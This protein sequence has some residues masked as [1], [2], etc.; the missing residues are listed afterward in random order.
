M[1]PANPAGSDTAQ[2]APRTPMWQA[3]KRRPR[4]GARC[5]LLPASTIK[6]QS[7]AVSPQSALDPLERL[8]AILHCARRAAA[9]REGELNDLFAAGEADAQLIPA[10]VEHFH[11]A[12]GHAHARLED[13][14]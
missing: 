6:A 5:R 12:L 11:R 14:T 10:R 1:C 9:G 3:G 13:P 8:A 7:L 2:R 4:R